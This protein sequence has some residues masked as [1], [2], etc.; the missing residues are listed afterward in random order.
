MSRTRVGRPA[1]QLLGRFAGV[2]QPALGGGEALVGGALL[3]FEPADRLP[4]LVL[5]AIERVALFL[6]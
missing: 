5:A 2:E 6:A 1:A 3:V 4:R